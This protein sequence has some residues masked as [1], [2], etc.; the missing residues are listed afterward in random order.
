MS[1]TQRFVAWQRAVGSR[2]SQQGH[3]IIDKVPSLGI[4]ESTLLIGFALAIGAVVGLAVI[5]FYNLIDFIQGLALSAADSLTGTGR[6]SVVFIVLAGIAVARY[7]VI[8]GT[9][10]SD[11]ENITDVMLAVAKRGALIRAWPPV[12][13]LIAAAA[14]IGTAGT[15]GAEGPVAVAGSSLG[16]R[17]GRFFRSGAP[18]LRVLVACG[19]A[20]GISAAFNAPIAGVFFSL[21]KVLGSF[22]VAAFPPILVASVIAAAISRAAFGNSPVIA[23][24]EEYGMG[25]PSE[26]LLYTLLG[27]AAG[28]AAVL[29]TRTLYKATDITEA[30]PGR[31]KQVL[32]AALGVSAVNYLLGSDLWGQG[33]ET[34]NLGLISERSW[35]VLLALAGGKL[36]TTSFTVAAARC[37]GVFTPSLFIGAT[38]GGGLAVFANEVLGFSVTPEAFALVGMAGVAAGATHAPLT[39]VMIVFEITSDYE[40]ILPLML[41]GAIA[42]ITAKRLYPDSI[43]STWLTRR[44]ETISQG[45]DEALLEQLRVRSCFNADPHVISES[46]TIPQIL[47]AIGASTQTEFPVIDNELR[48]VGMLTYN[49]LR[50]VVSEADQ[51]SPII[52]AGDL[53]G[54]GYASVTTEDSLRTALQRL[55][56]SG[57]HHI[58]VIDPLHPEKL[59][60]LISRTEIFGAYD[61]ALLTQSTGT[62]APQPG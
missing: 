59:L 12:M 26:L 52:M 6:L 11:G 60:G 48:F 44:G 13:K 50:T 28:A 15:V 16:S 58:P 40:L 2:L 51:L 35:Y 4:D 54:G 22:G 37:G 49:E 3:S 57:G 36:L 27:I 31:W 20:A 7:L 43:Y 61:R 32:F 19:A 14:L 47:K 17:L 29:F 41:T 34:L 1:Q 42:F 9:G 46:A 8:W 45:Q 38:L 10:D 30:I 18:R 53:I 21:E 39:A 55:A 25:P 5:V 33:H 56:I 62:G 24:P 23:I